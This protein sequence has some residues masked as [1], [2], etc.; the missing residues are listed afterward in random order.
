MATIQSLNKI[1]RKIVNG[2]YMPYFGYY[3]KNRKH[4][5]TALNMFVCPYDV[6]SC[7]LQNIRLQQ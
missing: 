5:H 3:S 2:H 7:I 1:N 6:N 4:K